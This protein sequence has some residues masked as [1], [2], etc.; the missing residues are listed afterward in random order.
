MQIYDQQPETA[1]IKWKR[2][3]FSEYLK[4]QNTASKSLKLVNEQY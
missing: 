2:K 3:S 1:H 4:I